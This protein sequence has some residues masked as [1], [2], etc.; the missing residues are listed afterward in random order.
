M[1]IASHEPALILWLTTP[2]SQAALRSVSD[3]SPPLIFNQ[4]TDPVR[5]SQVACQDHGSARFTGASDLSNFDAVLAFA[6]KPFPGAR[7]FGVLYNSGK[8]ID[9]VASE[10]LE[11]AA[12]RAGLKFNPVNV[13]PAAD[14]PQRAEHLRGNDFGD[15][16]GPPWYSPHCPPWSR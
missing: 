10:H 14:I 13:N 16:A 6:K 9:I 4:V 11:I 15:T 7:A 1:Q 3:N 8:T 2:V 12:A 5:A